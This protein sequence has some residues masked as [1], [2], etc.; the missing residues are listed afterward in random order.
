[1]LG[2]FSFSVEV[3]AVG[4]LAVVVVVV[5]VEGVSKGCLYFHIWGE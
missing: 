2:Y 4:T 1:M 3:E 5:M